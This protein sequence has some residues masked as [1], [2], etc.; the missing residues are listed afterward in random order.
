MNKTRFFKKG[1]TGAFWIRSHILPSGKIIAFAFAATN[2]PADINM[3]DQKSDELI[4]KY[5]LSDQHHAFEWR[6]DRFIEQ[7]ISNANWFIF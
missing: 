4:Q 5:H 7:E 2:P 1:E 3:V 6:Y